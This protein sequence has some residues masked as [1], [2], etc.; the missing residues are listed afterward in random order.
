MR[1]EK[2]L[3]DAKPN[4]R[5]YKIQDTDV[6]KYRLAVDSSMDEL[7]EWMGT[8]KGIVSRIIRKGD[9]DPHKNRFGPIK[10]R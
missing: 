7:N 2:A 6:R 4:E 10:F 1:L 8:L 3:T 9:N 5:P